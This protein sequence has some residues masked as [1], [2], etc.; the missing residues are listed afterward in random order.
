MSIF[1]SEIQMRYRS[2][3]DKS[4]LVLLLAILVIFAG[5]IAA[6]FL[7]NR[8]PLEIRFPEAPEV[9]NALR[10]LKGSNNIVFLELPD[11]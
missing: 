8:M 2:N 5:E 1:S 11:L 4:R 9:V 6:G 3:A 7:I 10:R